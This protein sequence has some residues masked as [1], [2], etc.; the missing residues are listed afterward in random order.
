MTTTRE[1]DF[2]TFYSP[3][4]LVAEQTR[5]PIESWDIPTACRM[6]K[7]VVE[8][9]AARPFS[10]AFSTDILAEDIDD[11]RG[12]KLRVEPKEIKRSGYHHLGGVVR[13]LADVERDNKPDENILRSNMRC[14]KIAAVIECRN[15]Y[16]STHPFAPGDVLVD[17][18]TGAVIARAETI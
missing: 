13:T 10:F 15:S 9:H 2:V 6:A 12:G 3:G 8:R 18:D 4:T 7:L 1:Q 5:K 16:R 17:P 11:G 14:N